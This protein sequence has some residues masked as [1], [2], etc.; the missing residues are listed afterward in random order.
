[1]THLAAFA[2]VPRRNS[3]WSEVNI[4]SLYRTPSG[5]NDIHN[6]IDPTINHDPTNLVGVLPG[7][8]VLNRYSYSVIM[9]M[10]TMWS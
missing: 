5:I 9:I 10:L 1:M 2:W 3:Y 4:A 8:K 7:N 6:A